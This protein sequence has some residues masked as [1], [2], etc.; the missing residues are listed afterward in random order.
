MAKAATF[1]QEVNPDQIKV[2]LKGVAEKFILYSFPLLM[3]AGGF[4]AK[5]L[6]D[7]GAAIFDHDKKIAVWEKTHPTKDEVAILND[8]LK[9]SIDELKQSI[10]DFRVELAKLPEK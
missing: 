9:K 2:S 7:H 6:I 1:E 10:N 3:A 8:G 4:V 5:T